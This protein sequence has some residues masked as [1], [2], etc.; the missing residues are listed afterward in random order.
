MQLAIQKASKARIQQPA[1]MNLLITPQERLTQIFGGG[2]TSAT[3]EEFQ[4][5]QKEEEIDNSNRE[6]N[7]EKKQ[8]Q[9]AGLFQMAKLWKSL[10]NE[11]QRRTSASEPTVQSPSKPR[12]YILGKESHINSQSVPRSTPCTS[13]ILSEAS[14]LTSTPLKRSFEDANKPE[15]MSD[16]NSEVKESK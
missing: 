15:K 7:L 5:R 12:N 1:T 16:K 14:F 4:V 10:E 8:Q 11:T 9:K 2:T 13:V 6:I 3:T